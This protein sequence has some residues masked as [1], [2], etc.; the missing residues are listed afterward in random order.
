VHKNT[1]S[2]LYVKFPKSFL[3]FKLC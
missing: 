2:D 1:F 3:M